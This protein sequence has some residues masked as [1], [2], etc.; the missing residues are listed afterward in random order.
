MGFDQSFYSSREANEENEVLYFRN[1][2][3]LDEQ[4]SDIIGIKFKPG[5]KVRLNPEDL[6]QLLDFIMSNSDTYFY[7]KDDEAEFEHLSNTFYKTVGIL[8]YFI[9]KDKPLYYQ[10][11]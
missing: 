4:I 8:S 2:Y 11:G 7:F 6:V 1:F 3:Q 9:F 10:A 5:D